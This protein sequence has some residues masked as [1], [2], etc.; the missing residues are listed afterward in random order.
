L[1]HLPLRGK[2]SLDNRFPFWVSRFPLKGQ[3][4]FNGKTEMKLRIGA[5]NG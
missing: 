2:A 3:S 5:N 4:V 1:G